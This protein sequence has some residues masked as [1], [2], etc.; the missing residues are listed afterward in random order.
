MKFNY[1]FYIKEA[2]EEGVAELLPILREFY[3]RYPSGNEVGEALHQLR[4]ELNL[5]VE[6]E[7]KKKRL[8]ELEDELYDKH[9]G[10]PG[11]LPATGT[12]V[13]GPKTRSRRRTNAGV[14]GAGD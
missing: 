13:D 10:E 7:A 2:D 8:K 4:R 5:I 1:P 9:D 6:V 11:A 12:D 14:S 3:T